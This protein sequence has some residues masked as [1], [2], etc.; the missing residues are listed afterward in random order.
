MQIGKQ[1]RERLFHFG[2]VFAALAIV[3]LLMAPLV[4]QQAR[5]RADGEAAVTSV[6]VLRQLDTLLGVVSGSWTGARARW[7]SPVRRCWGD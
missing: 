4:F 5:M 6:A 1:R 3:P 2:I 7:A